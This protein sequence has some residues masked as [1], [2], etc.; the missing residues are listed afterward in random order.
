MGN[1]AASFWDVYVPLQREEI[2]EFLNVKCTCN[3]GL[4]EWLG[5][6]F[7]DTASRRDIAERLEDENLTLEE[8][9]WYQIQNKVIFTFDFYDKKKGVRQVST[10]G[11]MFKSDE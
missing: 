10:I 4:I 8:K 3:E 5:R 1:T 6:Y 2:M 11:F 7:K 9:T